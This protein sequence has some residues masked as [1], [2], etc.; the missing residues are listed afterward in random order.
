MNITFQLDSFFGTTDLAVNTHQKW[1]TNNLKRNYFS[2]CKLLSVNA[3]TVHSS[4]CTVHSAQ[5]CCC[6]A[7]VAC[8]SIAKACH[9]SLSFTVADRMLS[10]RSTWQGQHSVTARTCNTSLLHLLHL[11][12]CGACLP[13]SICNAF[14]TAAAIGIATCGIVVSFA[15]AEAAN[16]QTPGNRSD[17]L[18]NNSNLWTTSRRQLSSIAFLSICHRL[19][20]LCCLT[21]PMLTI[22]N[23]LCINFHSAWVE[24]CLLIHWSQADD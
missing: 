15:F 17:K 9:F 4:Q 6:G 5:W 8:W 14:D 11:C 23:S 20:Q 7:V 3:F 13:I 18:I 24:S 16:W 19:H 10:W 21:F 2:N 22:L 12:S 1:A